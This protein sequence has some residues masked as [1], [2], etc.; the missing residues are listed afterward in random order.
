VFGPL[1]IQIYAGTLVRLAAGFRA[2][3][4]I[5]QPNFFIVLQLILDGFFPNTFQFIADQSTCL[6]KGTVPSAVQCTDSFITH[7]ARK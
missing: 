5:Q 4:Q 7:G 2:L 1:Q 3:L 6:S